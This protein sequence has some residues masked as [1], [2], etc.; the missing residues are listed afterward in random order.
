MFPKSQER[1]GLLQKH[2]PEDYDA[3][4]LEREE[5][6]D[7]DLEVGRSHPQAAEINLS[8]EGMTCSGCGDRINNGLASLHGILEC[9]AKFLSASLSA[10]YD[11]AALTP[12]SIIARVAE[13]GFTAR[14]DSGSTFSAEQ[15]S[16]L[17]LLLEG[18]D[19]RALGCDGIEDLVK[20]D[21]EL[22]QMVSSLAIRCVDDS[23]MLLTVQ[24]EADTDARTV[25]DRL[26][27]SLHPAGLTVVLQE[28]D[29]SSVPNAD[30]H[31]NQRLVVSVCLAIPIAVF[32][33]VTLPEG[34]LHALWLN[35][36]VR[37]WIDLL[38]ALPI[39]IYVALPL[40]TAAY[41]TLRYSREVEM[42]FLIVFSTSV[43]FLYSVVVMALSAFHLLAAEPWEI[44]YFYDTTAILI[45]LIVLGRWMEKQAKKNTTTI[46]SSLTHLHVT[47]ALLYQESSPNQ[48][49]EID[50]R[51]CRPGDLLRV[52]PGARIPLDGTVVSGASEVDESMLS[53]EPLPVPKAS[54]SAGY[55]GGNYRDRKGDGL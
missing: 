19:C 8:V 33:F 32:S 5:D 31:W 22:M 20:T 14:L 24:L 6:E 51:L 48:N 35:V 29:R 55:G 50:V 44:D 47:T 43:A 4:L 41:R 36:P 42:D 11:P 17:V 18:S 26:Y 45:T 54:G 40:Y 21:G 10:R 53:G 46:L 25:F 49:R 9:D 15:M 39:Q 28:P 34:F 27:A 52:L 12:E 37:I 13:L 2:V 23:S 16:E 7:G 1:E 30:A 3:S 38:C